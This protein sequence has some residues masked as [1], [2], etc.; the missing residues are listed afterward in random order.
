VKLGPKVDPV[1]VIAGKI[2]YTWELPPNWQGST[3]F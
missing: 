2:E 3:F 1:W